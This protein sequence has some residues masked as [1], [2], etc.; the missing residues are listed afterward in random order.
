MC[1]CVWQGRQ[2]RR[3]AP[4]ERNFRKNFLKLCFLTPGYRIDGKGLSSVL[5]KRP[6]AVAHSL[7]SSG[8]RH[9]AKEAFVVIERCVQRF[10]KVVVWCAVELLM[11][12]LWC[13]EKISEFSR[14]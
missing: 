1:S 7:Q 11:A 8:R 4:C 13:A 14:L 2:T 9:P 3:G 6:K 5:M 10:Y 12:Y